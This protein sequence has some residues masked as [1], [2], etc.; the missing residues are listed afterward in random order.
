MTQMGHLPSP[1]L[2]CV[3]EPVPFPPGAEIAEL[4][5]SPFVSA[6]TTSLISLFAIISKPSSSVLLPLILI[7]LVSGL[8]IGLRRLARGVTDGAYALP[9]IG[10]NLLKIGGAIRRPTL[11]GFNDLF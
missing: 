10:P 2:I 9:L 8:R 1:A 6:T 5:A 7:L 11:D 3:G 4:T